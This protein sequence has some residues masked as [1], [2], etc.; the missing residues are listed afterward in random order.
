LP[1]RANYTWM[2]SE[3]KADLDKYR[4]GGVPMYVII[5]ARRAA[6][7]FVLDELLTQSG[8]ISAWR[9]LL[10][11][12]AGQSSRPRRPSPPP[13]SAHPSARAD[14]HRRS[15]FR[16]CLGRALG[17]TPA[18]VC[19][20][21]ARGGPSSRRARVGERDDRTAPRLRRGCSRAHRPRVRLAPG[22]VP[23]TLSVH[24]P[25]RCYLSVRPPRFASGLV[26]GGPSPAC[27]RWGSDDR[28]AAGLR[29]RLVAAHRPRVRLARHRATQL[30]AA[31]HRCGATYPFDPRFALGAF[32]GGP[33][34]LAGGGGRMIERR[35]L[36]PLGSPSASTKGPAGAGPVATHRCGCHLSVR[37]HGSGWRRDPCATLPLWCYLSVRPSALR[38][39]CGGAISGLP[40]VGSDDRTG[41]GLRPRLLASASTTGRLAPAPV[42]HRCGAIYPLTPSF[43]LG[44]G[45]V[46]AILA[47]GGWGSDDRRR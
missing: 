17:A 34:P 46:V 1:F 26:G 47:R 11:A 41:A 2:D 4:R 29:P 19:G 10:P 44:L 27:P 15:R 24:P 7:A 33:S 25:L 22:P 3:I 39:G 43:A 16:L 36:R 37:P 35:G 12:A 40:E 20:V 31:T 38:S 13:A 32:G 21:P 45:W 30:S 6:D 28:T 18:Y 14:L 42:T 23:P 5:P 8:L 9:R